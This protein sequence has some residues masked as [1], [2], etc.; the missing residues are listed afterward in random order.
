MSRACDLAGSRV[1]SPADSWG[2]RSTLDTNRCSIQHRAAA[3][4]PVTLCSDPEWALVIVGGDN[5]NRVT[6]GIGR[7]LRAMALSP[8]V[9]QRLT[10]FIS[11]E[12]HSF[13]DRLAD[14]LEAG[15]V[16]AVI[17]SRFPVDTASTASVAWSATT[18][19]ARR[20]SWSVGTEPLVSNRSC[21]ATKPRVGPESRSRRTV[22]RAGAQRRPASRAA[23]TAALRSV[24]ASLR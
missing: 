22:R 23:C 1:T 5:G 10:T 13:I 2:F 19:A 20:S 9:A 8:F 14:Y 3:A 12:H 11:T 16:K 7:Q 17:A 4:G 6:R 21:A 15:T 18:P 24:T